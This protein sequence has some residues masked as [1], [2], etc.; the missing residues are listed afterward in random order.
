MSGN[1]DDK[2]QPLQ[3][4]GALIAIGEKDGKVILTF[5]KPTQWLPIDPETARQMAE[6]LAR[7]AY[8]ARFGRAPD[9][10]PR[11]MVT[12]SLRRHMRARA[13]L[14]SRSLIEQGRN[15]DYISRQ[16]VDL[17]LKEVA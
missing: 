10:K 12:E 2:V 14:V 16:L 7:S 17:I 8:T 6:Q 13:M 3:S 4:D 5:S 9:G 11:S 15:W 1:G